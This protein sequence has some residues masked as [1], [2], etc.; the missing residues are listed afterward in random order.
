MGNDLTCEQERKKEI[1]KA[2]EPSWLVPMYNRSA[3][4]TL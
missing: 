3:D 4:F 1:K 2:Y